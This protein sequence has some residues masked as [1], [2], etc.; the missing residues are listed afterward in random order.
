MKSANREHPL[1][2]KSYYVVGALDGLWWGMSLVG[3]GLLVPL[4]E[5]MFRDMAKMLA[6]KMNVEIDKET[7]ETVMKESA[8]AR[9]V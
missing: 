6:N 7:I 1:T 2:N 5:Q 3:A 8:L 4:R 9:A